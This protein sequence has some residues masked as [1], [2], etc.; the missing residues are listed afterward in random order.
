MTQPF[1][2]IWFWRATLPDRK[3]TPCRMLARGTMN[4]ALIEFTDGA[5]FIVSRNAFRKAKP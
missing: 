2:R 1:D 5:R 3:G 4:S